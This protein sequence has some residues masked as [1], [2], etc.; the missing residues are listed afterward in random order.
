MRVVDALC[1]A[2]SFENEICLCFVNACGYLKNTGFD[3]LLGRT[4]V[5]YPFFGT[6]KKLNQNKE[7]IIIFKYQKSIIDDAR[8]AYQLF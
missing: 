8:K 4:Q 7:E 2:R 6:I 3:V 1:Q 5:C